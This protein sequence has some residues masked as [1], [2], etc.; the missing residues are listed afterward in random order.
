MYYAVMA[1]LL[2][3]AI[4]LLV[5]LSMRRGTS[6]TQ[7]VPPPAPG[8]GTVQC[9]TCLGSGAVRLMQPRADKQ[10]PF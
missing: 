10:P 2:V 8:G 5:F 1:A 3:G 9:P 4:A 7:Y 6:T